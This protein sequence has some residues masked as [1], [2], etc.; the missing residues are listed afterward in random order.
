MKEFLLSLLDSWRSQFQCV[1]C[2]CLEEQLEYE[3]KNNRY[4]IGM[5][6]KGHVEDQ[7]SQPAFES[8]RPRRIPWH[9]KRREVEA[10]HKKD[11]DLA[12]DLTEGEKIFQKELNARS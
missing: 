9:Q 10:A 11:K 3:R 4:L 6:A 8:I 2:E 5:V 1:R 12:K 7:Q